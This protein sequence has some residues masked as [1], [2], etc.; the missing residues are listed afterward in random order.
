MGFTDHHKSESNETYDIEN[1]STNGYN[2]LQVLTDRYVFPS[3]LTSLNDAYES[4]KNKSITVTENPNALEQMFIVEYTL[5]R[6]TKY[7]Y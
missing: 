6:T 3:N 2:R 7:Y 1:E 4:S 5:M